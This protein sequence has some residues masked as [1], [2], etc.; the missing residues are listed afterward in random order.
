VATAISAISAVCSFCIP[1]VTKLLLPFTNLKII[2][3]I[4]SYIITYIQTSLVAQIVVDVAITI[5]AA[6]AI[7]NVLAKHNCL[8]STKSKMGCC[9]GMSRDGDGN[10]NCNGNSNCSVKKF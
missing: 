10:G 9:I 5:I 4:L 6:I 8:V 3:I 1:A 7:T 2:R